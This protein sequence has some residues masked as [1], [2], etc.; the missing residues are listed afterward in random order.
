MI[1]SC[2]SRGDHR[3]LIILRKRHSRCR[4]RP[5]EAAKA[6]H[7]YIRACP[8]AAAWRSGH[9]IRLRIGRPGFESRQGVRFMCNCRNV[10]T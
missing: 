3:N 6:V 1:K 9:R 7:K 5:Q 2:S 8:C 4:C 10:H